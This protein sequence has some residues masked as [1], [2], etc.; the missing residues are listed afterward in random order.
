MDLSDIDLLTGQA[1]FSVKL[2]ITDSNVSPATEQVKTYLRKLIPIGEQK[3]LNIADFSCNGESPEGV[4]VELV[5]ITDGYMGFSRVAVPIDEDAL[6]DNFGGIYQ[7]V[8][9]IF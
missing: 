6:M 9:E 4:T 1:V 3:P 7:S 2:K 8:E 5:S